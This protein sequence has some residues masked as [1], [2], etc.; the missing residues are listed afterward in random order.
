[1]I[2]VPSV[3]GEARLKGRGW[4]VA[5]AGRSPIRKPGRN[6]A[7]GASLGEVGEPRVIGSDPTERMDIKSSFNQPVLLD[8]LWPTS[9][10]S[11]RNYLGKFKVYTILHLRIDIIFLF[12]ND[13]FLN[14]LLSSD[15]KIYV[16]HVS[17]L[18]HVNYGPDFSYILISHVTVCVDL[19]P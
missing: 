14:D 2:P 15:N 17:L 16:I 19:Q 4:G 8:F 12:F 13:L 1:M 6:C 5:G 18:V 11:F 10:F 3:K 7:P 9:Q